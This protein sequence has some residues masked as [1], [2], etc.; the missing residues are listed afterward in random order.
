MNSLSFCLLLV[1]IIS[2][3]IRVYILVFSIMH[4]FSLTQDGTSVLETLS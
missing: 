1:V 2:Y 4:Y 3:K